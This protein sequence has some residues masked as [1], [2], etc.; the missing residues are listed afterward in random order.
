MTARFVRS[1]DRLLPPNGY[2]V[3][4][5]LGVFAVLLL[6]EGGNGRLVQASTFFSVMQ[7]FATLGP[8][9]LAI[10]LTMIAGEFDLS[11]AG[12]FAAAGAVAVLTGQ[13]DPLLGLAC[14]VAAGTAFGAL[15]GS[16]VVMLRIPAIALTLGGLLF[17]LGFTY[18]LTGGATI[19]M[20]DRTITTWLHATPVSTVLS[21]RAALVVLLFVLAAAILGLS[22]YGRDLIAT[23]SNRHGARVAGVNTSGILICVFALSGALAA[24]GGAILSFSLAAASAVGLSDVLV[25][26]VT[27]A[28][29]GGVSL[30]GGKGRPLGIA[31]GVVTFCLLRSGLSALGIHPAMLETITGGMLLTVAILDAPAFTERMRIWLGRA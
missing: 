10:G 5:L 26:A 22:R 19:N 28:I 8:V 16:L 7:L 21:N 18:V 1:I 15:Q 14:A 12:V 6:L 23:G 25:P 29:L 11:V 20:T 2:P 27:A 31:V 17:T 24:F 13:N 30:G 4:A 9:A 3:L